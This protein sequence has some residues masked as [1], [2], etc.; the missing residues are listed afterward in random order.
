[1]AGLWWKEDILGKKKKGYYCTPQKKQ[2]K[3]ETECRRAF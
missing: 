1:M 3:N 2:R